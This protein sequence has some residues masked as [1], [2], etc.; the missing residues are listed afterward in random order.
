M[1]PWLLR[2]E[3][4][5]WLLFG[6]GILIGTILLTGW[7]LVVGV[8]APLGV[9]PEGALAYERAHRLAAHP[10]GRLVL[11]ALIALPLWKGAHH[12]RALSIDFGGAS[13]DPAIAP[14]LYAIALGGS[15]LALLAVIRL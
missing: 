4:L 9:V 10:L 12:L 5:V 2:I 8:L 1:K 13:R 11:L 7:L 3:P 14:L 6:Q 15:A